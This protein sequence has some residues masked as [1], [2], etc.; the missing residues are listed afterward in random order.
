MAGIVVCMIDSSDMVRRQQAL[1]A[2]PVD[3]NDIVFQ[4]LIWTIFRHIQPTRHRYNERS[5]DIICWSSMVC[6]SSAYCWLLNNSISLV[7]QRFIFQKE[8]LALIAMVDSSWM[9]VFRVVGSLECGNAI[10]WTVVLFSLFDPLIDWSWM[11]RSLM[12][13]LF[14]WTSS[15]MDCWLLGASWDRWTFECW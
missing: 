8:M 1:V 14:W 9:G 5:T 12:D 4:R 2:T 6:M 10:G 13:G 11:D 7:I 15:W 3:F